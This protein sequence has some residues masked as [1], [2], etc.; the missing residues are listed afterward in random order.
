MDL[1]RR[2]V[3][4]GGG[5]VATELSSLFTP[6]RQRRPDFGL[7]DLFGVNALPAPGA[8]IGERMLEIPP[9]QRQI[10]RGRVSY[11]AAI[12]AAIPKPPAAWMTK[13]YWKLP[14]NWEELIGQVRWAAGGK[15]SLEV[16]A[17][18]TLAVVAELIEQPAQNRRIAHLLNYAAPNGAAVNDLNVDVELPE[19]KQVR[20][21]TLL[22]PD[23]GGATTIPNHVENGRVR[24]N[25]PRLDTYT[26]AIIQME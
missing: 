23:G 5:L 6:W 18:E 13:Q 26:L 25:V 15:L 7:A 12:K 24:F 8:H 16:D 20:Q 21:V 17:P 9:V 22:S 14:L 3:N 11:V 19:G 2:Y 1:I 4:Q 10:G